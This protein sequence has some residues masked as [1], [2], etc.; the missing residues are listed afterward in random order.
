M[1]VRTG[2]RERAGENGLE[3]PGWS[4]R[5]GE[6]SMTMTNRID[7]G[8]LVPDVALVDHD[9]NRWRFSD[10]RGRPILLVLHRHLG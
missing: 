10:H 3:R 5:A 7:E 1:L 9:G 2:W 4:G 6:V 8:E